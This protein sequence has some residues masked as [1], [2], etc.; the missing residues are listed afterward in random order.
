[1][2]SF[3]FYNIIYYKVKGE[4]KRKEREWGYGKESNG[5]SRD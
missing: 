1:L 2:K 4:Q 5:T 3:N